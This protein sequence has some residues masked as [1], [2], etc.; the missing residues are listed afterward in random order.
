V[1]P[2]RLVMA[3]AALLVGSV[4]AYAAN[5]ANTQSGHFFVLVGGIAALFV[6]LGLWR[7]VGRHGVK[8][9]LETALRLIVAVPGICSLHA[10][11]TRTEQRVL[12]PPGTPLATW[13]QP[14][15]PMPSCSASCAMH[16]AIGAFVRTGIS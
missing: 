6:G 16:L 8:G 2:F 12:G 15:P 7:A 14:P 4:P 9:L 3:M 11:A 1:I 5:Q 13:P 10:S